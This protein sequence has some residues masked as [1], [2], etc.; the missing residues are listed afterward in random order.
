M[1]AEEFVC[2]TKSANGAEASVQKPMAHGFGVRPSFATSNSVC[3]QE[4]DGLDHALSGRARRST[5]V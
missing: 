3:A 5:N 4:G 2:V 1:V